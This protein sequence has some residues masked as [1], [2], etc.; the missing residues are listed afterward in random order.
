MHAIKQAILFWKKVHHH[1]LPLASKVG[2]K[3]FFFSF[4][5]PFSKNLCHSFR[6][7]CPCCVLLLPQEQGDLII[8]VVILNSLSFIDRILLP[9]PLYERRLLIQAKRSLSGFKST[10]CPQMRFEAGKVV[11]H[12][13]G[14]NICNSPFVIP[15]PVCPILHFSFQHQG[16]YYS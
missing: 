7:Q 15:W 14:S 5:F 16:Q 3:S 12:A 8:M 6:V 13:A 2:F 9:W 10:D 1:F 11:F 4:F